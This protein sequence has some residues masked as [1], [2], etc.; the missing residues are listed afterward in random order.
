MVVFETPSRL[1]AGEMQKLAYLE[2]KFALFP[3]WVNRC[4]ESFLSFGDAL[5]VMAKSMNAL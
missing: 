5:P 3:S 2:V 4:N 1:E